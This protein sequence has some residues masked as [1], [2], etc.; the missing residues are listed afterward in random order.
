MN[1]RKGLYFSLL[2]P[3]LLFGLAQ[4]FSSPAISFKEDNTPLLAPLNEDFL[5][6]QK[7]HP[8]QTAIISFTAEGYPLGLI[9]SPHDVSYFLNIPPITIKGL[10]PFFDLRQTNKLTPVKNQGNCGS[11]WA[12]ATYASLESLLLPQESWDF[13]EQ[14]LIDNNGYD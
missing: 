8:G 7:L 3:A 5:H 4:V 6:F 14:N 1:Q 9:P 11:C 10:P 13:S 12:F 2:L